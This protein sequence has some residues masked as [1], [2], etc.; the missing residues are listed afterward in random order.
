[1]RGLKKN[2]RNKIAYGAIG[3][4]SAFFI[5]YGAHTYL[6]HKTDMK[7][8]EFAQSRPQLAELHKKR[9]WLFYDY[10]TNNGYL[11]ELYRLDSLRVNHYSELENVIMFEPLREELRRTNKILSD[12]ENEIKDLEQGIR[13][14][15]SKDEELNV[16]QEKRNKYKRRSMLPFSLFMKK[17]KGTE[18]TLDNYPLSYGSKK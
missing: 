4:V 6:A 13:E 11:T 10:D 17:T 14:V 8:A 18:P 9:D 16:L 2:L 3:L 15:Y 12:M 7:I 1:M 5:N